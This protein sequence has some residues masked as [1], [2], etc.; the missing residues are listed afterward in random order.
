MCGFVTLP[1]V[2]PFLLFSFSCNCSKILLEFSCL[3]LFMIS[4]LPW[5]PLYIIIVYVVVKLLVVIIFS[6]LFTQLFKD[7]A[8]D[9]VFGLHLVFNGSI[10]RVVIADPIFSC[11]FE[12]QRD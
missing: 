12:V 5:E 10:Y 3:P 6:I 1:V 8:F 9:F 4:R 11:D 7:F 2:V